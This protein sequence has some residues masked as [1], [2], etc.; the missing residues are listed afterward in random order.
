MTKASPSAPRFPLT[1]G[2]PPGSLTR[3]ENVATKPFLS[4]RFVEV[5][6]APRCQNCAE[7]SRIPFSRIVASPVRTRLP[8]DPKLAVT[9]CAWVIVSWQDPVPEQAPDDP[10]KLDP[11]AAV[12]VRTTVV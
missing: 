10:A 7:V 5:H 12:A 9:V 6:A 3:K 11:R 4:G 8:A 2:G 1:S